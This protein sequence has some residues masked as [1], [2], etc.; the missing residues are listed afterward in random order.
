MHVLPKVSTHLQAKE[1]ARAMHGYT[2]QYDNLGKIGEGTYGV[3]IK[4]RDR[5]SGQIVAIK[6]FKEYEDEEEVIFN[7]SLKTLSGNLSS[8][9]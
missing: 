1:F 2:G 9:L 3:V 5:V 7:Y 8:Y 6:K 4:S